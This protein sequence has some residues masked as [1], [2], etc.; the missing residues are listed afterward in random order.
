MRILIH[1]NAPWVGSGYGQQTALLAPRLRELGHTVAISTITGLQGTATKWRDMDVYPSGQIAFSPDTLVEH[2]AAFRA[3]VI[4]TCMD[5]RMLL[6]AAQT[7]RGF[8]ILAWMPVDTTPLSKEDAAIL[9][10]TGATPIA[11]SRFGEH[12]LKGAGF[13]P[14]YAPHMVDRS[15]FKPLPDRAAR[16]QLREDAGIAADDFV[17]G[18][19]AANSDQLRKGFPEQFE[20]FRRFASHGEPGSRARLLVHSVMNTHHGIHLGQLADDLD[21]ADRVIFSDT[22]AQ[23]AGFMQPDDMARWFQCCD[24]LSQCSYGE[25]FGIPLIEAQ[26]CGIPVVAN[27]GSAMTELSVHGWRT[28]AT[29]FFVQIHRAWWMRPDIG[30]IARCYREAYRTLGAVGRKSSMGAARR[31]AAERFAAGYEADRVVDEYWRPVLEAVK[32][33]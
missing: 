25:G 10:A 14:L 18:I 22:Y 8:P 33:K 17:I 5:F 24:V 13:A 28:K 26:A 6:P 29:P 23:V 30:D 32:P 11:M 19:C 1:S 2:A 16:D 21:I 15:V 20:A 31:D 4:L 7:L 3:D 27:S 9:H 12:Q